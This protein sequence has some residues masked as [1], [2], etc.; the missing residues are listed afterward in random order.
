MQTM[1]AWLFILVS[2]LVILPARAIAATAELHANFGSTTGTI[3]AELCGVNHGVLAVNM[4]GY[5]YNGSNG[6]DLTSEYNWCGVKW[7]RT[8]EIAAGDIL[9]VFPSGDSGDV[10]NASNYH[11]TNLDAYLAPCINN[12][13]KIIFRL[14]YSTK[15]TWEDPYTRWYPPTNYDRYATI[16]RNTYKHLCKNSFG[17]NGHTWPITYWEFYNEPENP[18]GTVWTGTAT[19]FAQLYRKVVNALKAE[20]SSVKVGGYGAW[21]LDASGNID[22]SE[23]RFMDDFLDYCQSNSV[24]LDCFSFHYYSDYGSTVRDQAA[25]IR[26]AL[27]SHGY[28]NAEI[29]NTEWASGTGSNNDTAT[30]AAMMASS[31]ILDQNSDVSKAFYYAGSPMAGFIW[32]MWDWNSSSPD[33]RKKGFYGFT[34]YA[35]L[36]YHTPIMCSASG[37]E[38]MTPPLAGKNAAAT[39]ARILITNHRCDTYN[40]YHVNVTNLPFSDWTY[41]LFVVDSS[42]NLANCASRTGSGTSFQVTITNV[43]Y[44]SI[45]V[46]DFAKRY[47][48][49]SPPA[50]ISTPSNGVVNIKCFGVPTSNYVVQTTTNLGAPWWAV[51]TNAAGDDGSWQFTDPNATRAQ[52]YYRVVQP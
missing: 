3:N 28:T 11:F 45:Y 46:L 29:I 47:Y 44:P 51:S 35:M 50:R 9:S 36:A 15:Y 26:S 42:N 10:F 19:Q 21:Q 34:T 17:V 18:L 39:D 20:D 43:T 41:T 4:P 2:V 48:S 8:D 32:G 31:L 27:D 12:G 1:K 40:T 24:A 33:A 16:C 38:A 7:I 49:T 37:P 6:V 23:G 14:G 13:N 52:Q 30:E 5:A 25:H 22:T